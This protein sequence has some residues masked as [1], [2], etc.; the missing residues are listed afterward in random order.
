MSWVCPRLAPGF[1]QVSPGVH[2]VCPRVAPCLSQ[3]C[4]RFAPGLPQACPKKF[5]PGLPQS[6]SKLAPGLISSQIQFACPVV[7]G[8]ASRGLD[9]VS[10][11]LEILSVGRSSSRSEAGFCQDC[12]QGSRK[13]L[14]RLLARVPAR[15]QARIPDRTLAV[16]LARFQL[17]F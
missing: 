17:G 6:C 3:V 7:F 9:H 11:C 14:A 5:A 15:V 12:S 4:P 10:L 1:S 13:I 8:R 2:Q 16:I